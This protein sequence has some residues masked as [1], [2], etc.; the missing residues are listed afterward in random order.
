MICC[1][2]ATMPVHSCNSKRHHEH[3]EHSGLT[4]STPK[5]T[6]VAGGGK[7]KEEKLGSDH[8]SNSL[9]LLCIYPIRLRQAACPACPAAC[10]A[11]GVCTVRYVAG[12]P[13]QWISIRI[14]VFDMVHCPSTP[15]T[16]SSLLDA[17]PLMSSRV[18]AQSSP[19]QSKFSQA[20]ES[21]SSF[22]FDLLPEYIT[23]TPYPPVITDR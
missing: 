8:L 20:P 18:L 2:F 3:V 21:L 5:L 15:S 6:G 10:P 11:Y 7:A 12:H 9:H 22:A 1:R 23:C 17:S 13:S 19:V 4:Q 14:R 16:G